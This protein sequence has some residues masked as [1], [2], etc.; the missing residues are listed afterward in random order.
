MPAPKKPT[1]ARRRCMMGDCLKAGHGDP[2]LCAKHEAELEEEEGMGGQF[3]EAI[4]E[5]LEH[6]R[7]KRVVDKAY[8]ILDQLGGFIDQVKRGEVPRPSAAG[9]PPPSRTPVTD[10]VLRARETLHFDPVEPLTKEKI[11]DRYRTLAKLVHP[12]HG[13]GSNAAMARINAA[14]QLLNKSVTP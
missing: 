8:G 9:A 3:V 4:D 11:R 2:P 12:D 6:P 13:G 14:A 7:V 10:A 5:V 1:R